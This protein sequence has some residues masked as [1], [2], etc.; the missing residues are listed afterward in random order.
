MALLFV[1]LKALLVIQQGGQG[2]NG[3]T[4]AVCQVS[5][6]CVLVCCLYLDIC[7][8]EYECFV[9]SVAHVLLA[10]CCL[11]V[12]SSFPDEFVS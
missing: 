11:H 10:L 12:V 8:V 6:V 1:T 9:A 5:D 4:I 2:K 3:S 7:D